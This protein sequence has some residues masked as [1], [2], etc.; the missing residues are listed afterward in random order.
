MPTPNS[1]VRPI[2]PRPNLERDR[3]QAKS[4]LDAVKRGDP[5]ALEQFKSFHP[6][7]AELAGREDLALH[8]AQL[9]IARQ[10]GFASWPR[11][12][13]FV[14]T[15]RLDRARRAAELIKA[16]CSN[17]VRKARV[18][19]EAEADLARFDLATACACGEVE[20]AG[21]I[22]GRDP[23]LAKQKS[24]PLD[25][26]P[27]LYACFSRFLR[28]DPV[29]ARGIVQCARILLDNGADP[30]SHYWT[31]WGKESWLQSTL[32]GAAGIANNIELTTMLLDAGARVDPQDKE[33]LY[34]SS[35]FPD[36]GCLGLILQRGSPPKEQIDYCIGRATDFEYPEHVRLFLEAGADPNFRVKWDG[37]RTQLHKAVY[38]LRS[39]RIVKMLIDAGG[40]VN[41]VDEGGISILRSAVRNGDQEVAELLQS[42]GARDES[43]TEDDN[44]KGDRITLC[45]AASRN[46]LSAIRR[47]LDAGA[48]PNGPAAPDQTPPLHWAAWRGRLAALQLLVD[49]GADIH[50]LNSY[51]GNAIGMA[52]H[53]SCHCFDPEGGPGMK[54][55][56]EA[57]AGEY[58]QIIEFLISRGAKLP[59]KIREGSDAVQEVLRRHGV[60]DAD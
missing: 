11:W 18:M 27:I 49:R 55:P 22:L 7:F 35:E 20:T 57:V 17:D 40:D 45:L 12:K 59:E 52:I 19:L 29:R 43:I 34:H 38:L 23:G 50:W 4:L 15:R 32:Y 41:A 60:P 14:E 56:E 25:I 16:A 6:R 21:Q 9:V 48:D 30:N 8:D 51:G 13:Q 31:D 33:A 53:G 47:L 42:R 1:P 28:A 3:K 10:Y 58:P 39:V 24:G 36:P 37:L 44:L 2:P 46:D 26:E 54:L 5:A